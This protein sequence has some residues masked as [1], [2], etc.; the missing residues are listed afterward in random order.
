VRVDSNCVDLCNKRGYRF[1]YPHLSMNNF[2]NTLI[3]PVYCSSD[4]Y[5]CTYVFFMVVLYLCQF[6]YN[7]VPNLD[8]VLGSCHAGLWKQ[9]A[10]VSL[11]RSYLM[12]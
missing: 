5:V 8:T 12:S 1:F 7:K 2:I 10:Q 11:R 3:F 6:Y 4:E 9:I